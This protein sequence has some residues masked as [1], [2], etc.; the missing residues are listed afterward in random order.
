MCIRDSGRP[1]RRDWQ[2]AKVEDVLP[3]ADGLVRTVLLRVWRDLT[4]RKKDKKKGDYPT[5]DVD[6]QT[7]LIKR[8]INKICLLSP[9]QGPE[10]PADRPMVAEVESEGEEEAQGSG[11]Q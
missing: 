6:F 1:G 5:D 11:Q 9:H 8:A 7:K 4:P 3:S 10:V 2:L